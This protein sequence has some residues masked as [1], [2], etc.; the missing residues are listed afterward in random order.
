GGMPY[1]DKF[2]IYFFVGAFGR[3]QP[4]NIFI[5]GNSPETRG[6]ANLEYFVYASEIGAAMMWRSLRVAFTITDISKT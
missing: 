5:Q 1:S 6:I 3:F 4:L 2:S